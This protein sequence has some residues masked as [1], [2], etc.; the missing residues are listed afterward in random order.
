M[1]T[2]DA[3]SCQQCHQPAV[4]G[5]AF[6]EECGARLEAPPAPIEEAVEAVEP[7]ATK[8][9]EPAPDPDSKPKRRKRKKKPADKVLLAWDATVRM[10]GDRFFMWDMA[11]LWAI[12]CSF[13]L[14]LSLV[15]TVIEQSPHM[16][17]FTL[18]VPPLTFVGFYVFS[19]LIAL[20][21]FFNKYFVETVIS[22]R[23]VKFELVR[24]TGKLSKAVAA[25]NIII[26]VLKSAPGAVGAGVLANV[27]RSVFMKW[28]E[29]RKVTFFPR[30]RVVTLSNSWRPVVRLHCPDDE[31]YEQL[32]VLLETKVPEGGGTLS[33][34]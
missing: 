5:A 32:R 4:P 15:L 23:G 33:R 14:I 3:M 31:I 6:C 19:L 27:Q 13:L 21:F 26:G 8:A 29:I 30:Q 34:S 20:V 7:T 25:G 28:P 1:T 18:I 22:E 12:S 9:P 11:K 17:R 24:W 16:L 10:V 2:D